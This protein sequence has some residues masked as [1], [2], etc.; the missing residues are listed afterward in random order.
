VP[1]LLGHDRT[2]LSFPTAAEDRELS[3][4]PSRDTGNVPCPPD[5]HVSADRNLLATHQV[6]NES[7]PCAAQVDRVVY[8]IEIDSDPCLAAKELWLSSPRA[9]TC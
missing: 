2:Q 7:Y 1:A 3:C 8:P 4:P 5:A 9:E 6:R